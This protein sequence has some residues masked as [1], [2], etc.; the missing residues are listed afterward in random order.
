MLP[1][2]SRGKLP[3]V[4]L[5]E[6]IADDNFSRSIGSALLEVVAIGHSFIIVAGPTGLLRTVG[7]LA[8]DRKGTPIKSLQSNLLM[9]RDLGGEESRKK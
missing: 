7:D 8:V 3:R 1:I 9:D 2:H 6:G 4:F 5:I